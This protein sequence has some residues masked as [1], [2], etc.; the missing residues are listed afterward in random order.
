MKIGVNGRFLTK[1]FTGIGQYTLHMVTELAKLMKKDEFV[2][3][4]P[5]KLSLKF[6]KNVK[7]K[8]VPER[9]R[10]MAGL[11]KTWWEQIQVPELFKKENVDWA[12]FPYPSNPWP[13]DFKIKTLVTVHDTIPWEDKRYQKG[14]LSRMYHQRSKKAVKNADL[15]ITVS[16]ASKKAI[17]RVCG[18][19][20]KVIY[21]DVAPVYRKSVA[22]GAVLKKYK[23]EKE[24]Y[25]LYCGGFDVRKNVNALIKAYGQFAKKNSD[26]QL[27]LAGGKILDGNLYGSF[28]EVESEFGHIVKTG[29][30]E[31]KHLAAL[32][33]NCLGFVH[34]SEKEGFNIPVVEA[35]A[36]ASPLILSDIPVHREVAGGG[37][38]FVKNDVAPAM[39]KLLRGRAGWSKKAKRVAEKFSWKK[40]AQQLKDMLS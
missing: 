2:L 30:L 15:V 40:S 7:V 28:D 29:F 1:P 38:Q 31:E 21:N 34:L 5:E 20:S 23:L 39:R 16:Q 12:W 26:I 11:R 22:A 9:R 14:V 24:K 10:G 18:K 37:A 33:Q 19:R 6:P 35:A 13:R 17:Q 3:I 8:V 25:F 36:C 32:Y 4:V 27:V